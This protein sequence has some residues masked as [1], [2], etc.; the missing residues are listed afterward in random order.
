M[1]R[2]QDQPAAGEMGAHELGQHG[3]P[4]GVERGGRLIEQPDRPLDRNQAGER[5]AAA[6]PGGEIARG[7]PGQPVETD[8]GKAP[9]RPSPRP[10]EKIRPESE[11]L[12]APRARA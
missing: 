1:G 5:K 11:V 2:G 3:L 12:I 10:A 8:G 9:R 4:H 6:L 7:Q